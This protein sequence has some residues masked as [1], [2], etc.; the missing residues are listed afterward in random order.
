MRHVCNQ[1]SAMCVILEMQRL[2][3]KIEREIE[4]KRT[5]RSTPKIN[6]RKKEACT[7]QFSVCDFNPDFD[8]AWELLAAPMGIFPACL[9]FLMDKKNDIIK[10]S[11]CIIASLDADR[12]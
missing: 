8:L 5:E 4:K 1:C 3:D 12:S 11:K 2:F 6:R 10:Q 7:N 9:L